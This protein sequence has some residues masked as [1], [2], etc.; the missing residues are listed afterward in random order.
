MSGLIKT[1]WLA[2]TRRTQENVL[3]ALAHTGKRC[4]T[5]AIYFDRAQLE[6]AAPHIAGP[7]LPLATTVASG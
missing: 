2:G 5:L 3:V 1:L 4:R 7:E 6:D